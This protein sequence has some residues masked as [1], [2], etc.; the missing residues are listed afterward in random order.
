MDTAFKYDHPELSEAAQVDFFESILDR[1]LVAEQRL[2]PLRIRLDIAGIAI[3]ISQ[4][5]SES[6]PT[7]E[8]IDRNVHARPVPITT[9]EA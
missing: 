8:R 4:D 3:E 2:R 9:T 7:A 5:A 1:T 6:A